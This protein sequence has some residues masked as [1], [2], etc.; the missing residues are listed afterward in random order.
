M[1]ESKKVYYS[2]KEVSLLTGLPFSTLRFW[3]NTFDE[4]QPRRNEGGTRFYTDDDIEVI[5]RIQYLRDNEKMRVPA[6]RKRLRLDGQKKTP[7]QRA[8]ELLMQI[9]AELN[10]IKELL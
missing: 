5:R 4:L 8:T 6:I 9:R 2:I 3:E 1:A 10:D 7:V